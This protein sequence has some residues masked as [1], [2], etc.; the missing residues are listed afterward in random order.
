MAPGACD[1][2]PERKGTLPACCKGSWDEA[3]GEE[4][5]QTGQGTRA[6]SSD[7]TARSQLCGCLP[8][9]QASAYRTFQSSPWAVIGSEGS[10]P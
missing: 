10:H 9:R 1:R 4:A 3:G 6:P 7:S 8:S 5:G 2:K